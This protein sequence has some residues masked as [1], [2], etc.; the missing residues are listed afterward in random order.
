MTF[1]E[2]VIL[3]ATTVASATPLVF[4][5]VGETITERA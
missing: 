3:I 5:V 2:L 1:E 4:A